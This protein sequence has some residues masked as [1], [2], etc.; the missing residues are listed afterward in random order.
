MSSRRKLGFESLEDRRVFAG[1]VSVSVVGGELRIVGDNA[2]NYVNVQLKTI[3]GMKQFLVTGIPFTG[4]FNSAGDPIAGTTG[5]SATLINGQGASFNA[6]ATKVSISMGGG[7]DAVVLGGGTN[8]HEFAVQSL[9]ANLG[10]GSDYLKIKTARV[11]SN[12][13]TQ[14]LMTQATAAAAAA[15]EAGNDKIVLEGFNSPLAGAKLVMG[16]GND[17]IIASKINAKGTGT[18]VIVDAGNGVDKMSL[19]NAALFN[20]TFNG[21][22][23]NDRFTTTD[24]SFNNVTVNGGDGNDIVIASESRFANVVVNGGNGSDSVTVNRV[25]LNKVTLNMGTSAERDT[26]TVSNT[27]ANE[28]IID[29]GAGNGDLLNLITEVGIR[30][31]TILKGGAGTGD[32]LRIGNRQ[33]VGASNPTITGFEIKPAGL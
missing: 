7:N 10:T 27:A 13:T 21:G 22:I 20:V 12:V 11:T 26:V 29:M 30:N 33:R 6:A 8:V 14:L 3:Q 1:D 17:Q 19:A 24:S 28:A 16:G 31:R 4:Q 18:S 23:G 32:E 25:T 9:K 15:S 5:A 2:A